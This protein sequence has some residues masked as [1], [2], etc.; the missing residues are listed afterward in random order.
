MA[1]YDERGPA[2]FLKSYGFELARQYELTH[3]GKHVENSPK[4]SCCDGR[5]RPVG[6]CAAEAGART[7]GDQVGLRAPLMSPLWLLPTKM[8]G[9]SRDA[10]IYYRCASYQLGSERR[11]QTDF[12]NP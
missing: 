12:P 2:T 9:T 6:C 1:E 5:V 4:F 11:K 3:D 8:E 10:R 7:E